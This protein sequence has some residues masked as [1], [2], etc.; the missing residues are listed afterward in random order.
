MKMRI[1]HVTWNLAGLAAPL[2]VAAVALPS[3]LHQLGPQR[4][5]VLA[6]AWGL[7]GYASAIDLGIGRAVTRM[8]A[9]MLNS[10]Q[11]TR[12]NDVL[13]AG[14][15]ITIATGAIAFLLIAVAALS[16]V[17]R[18]LGANEI[19]SRE[20][21][22]S[23]LLLALALPM[24]SISATYKGVN[25][26]HLNFRKISLLKIG[27]GVANFGAPWLISLFT[28]QMHWVIASLVLSRA[29]SLYLYRRFAIALL[30]NK[31]AKSSRHRTRQ[32]RILKIR[33]FKFG[34]WLTVSSVINPIVNVA[35]R[36]LV[37]YVISAAAVTSY[38]IPFEMTT[39]S[40]ILVGAVTTV[41]FPYAARIAD[42]DP[43]KLKKEFIKIL[44]VSVAVMA[45]TTLCYLL[46]G[47]KV[48]ALWLGHAL[49]PDAISVL[50]I[51]SLGLAPYS[52]ASVST[53]FIH[54]RGLSKV[55]ALVH[56]AAFFPSLGLVY[57]L[58]H[59]YGLLGAAAAW[60]IRITFE[61]AIF[62]WIAWK[63]FNRLDRLGTG[64]SAIVPVRPQATSIDYAIVV[65]CHNDGMHAVRAIKTC[66]YQACDEL[67]ILSLDDGS[68]DDSFNFV[69]QKFANEA[70]VSCYVVEKNS[71][72]SDAEKSGLSESFRKWIIFLDS[73][74]AVTP[75]YLRG[76]TDYLNNVA[77]LGGV[78]LIIPFFH[79]EQRQHVRINWAT[80]R[81]TPM[82]GRMK[83]FNLFKLPVFDSFP[84][85]AGIFPRLLTKNIE[86]FDEKLSCCEN[87]SLWLK[88]AKQGVEFR[89][90]KSDASSAA[91][92][93]VRQ[94]D[95]SSRSRMMSAR[96]TVAKEHFSGSILPIWQ[97]PSIEKLIRK[98]IE[99]Y[100][101]LIY[102]SSSNRPNLTKRNC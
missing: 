6:L 98:F 82:R 12:E 2:A 66:L 67:K 50:Q 75:N 54:S 33:L 78:V 4:F 69:K 56:T 20:K 35:D 47:G 87:S 42:H 88:L 80:A 99:G 61:A 51:I 32:L 44:L 102:R 93:G 77:V 52:V 53:S 57:G 71:S 10:T 21:T 3:L 55:T 37:A 86:P 64:F 65:P 29:L 62:S 81:R 49:E 46:F 26:A 90:P 25:E 95:S 16:G 96:R 100:W 94:G 84:V 7:I 68:L 41:F 91:P 18:F 97:F 5:G 38:V 101:N 39:Q 85:S 28:V 17:E 1:S 9:G 92:I 15:H 40:L 34:G 11:S 31:R 27:L 23:I 73:E 36:F 59:S 22:F 72:V 13:Q 24:Q 43:E 76:A 58:I 14:L 60:V 89:C 83:L 79:F 19:P 74:D 70:R 45:S 30:P 63:Q 48:L 8:I